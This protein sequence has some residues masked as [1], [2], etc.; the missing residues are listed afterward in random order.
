M[1]SN[2]VFH[3]CQNICVVKNMCDK[4]FLSEI[5]STKKYLTESE[6]FC[7]LCFLSEYLSVKNM[8]CNANLSFIRSGQQDKVRMPAM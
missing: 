5:Y 7:Q 6:Y 1:W 4:H 2:V 3:D 8:F